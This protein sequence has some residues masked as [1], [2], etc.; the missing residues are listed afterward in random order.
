[1]TE[2]SVQDE[3][4]D[5]LK[6]RLADAAIIIKERY[7]GTRPFRFEPPSERESL[8][9]YLSMTPEQKI[10]ARQS[11]GEAYDFYEQKMEAL[12]KKFNAT[13]VM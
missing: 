10:F 3:A 7:K 13:E 11:F 4:I 9:N 12:K 5:I 8:F 2:K 1:M 6:E